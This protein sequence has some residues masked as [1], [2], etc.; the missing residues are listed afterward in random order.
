[1]IRLA[2]GCPGNN[3]DLECMAVLSHSVLKHASEP[4]EIHWLM[5]SRD[6]ASFWYA[7]PQ[8]KPRK[9]W[10][11]RGWATPFS[12]LRLGLPA[13]FKFEGKV[14]YCDSD[15]IFL[16]DCAELWNQPIP[17]GK[18][19]LMSKDGASCVMLMD[20]AR[21][22]D[23][24]PP[25]DKLKSV[26]GM[27]RNVRGAL[28]KAA[29]VYA[30]D[31]NCRDGRGYD[32]I[33]HPDV[34]ILHYTSIPTQPNHRHARAR[35]RAEGKKHWFP[36]P[37]LPHPRKEITELFDAT[38]AEAIAAGRGPETFRVTPEFGDYGR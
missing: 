29:G 5:L 19:L 10:N 20:C 2:V 17:D 38:L 30:G 33:H 26:E 36:G 11:T 4:V 34:K 32:S 7:D 37:D 9:G 13:F 22:R 21:M 16:A 31:W 28:V 15:Q 18:A 25:I 35:L 3:E 8:A 6:P 12:P 14:I 1:M 24:L 27:F 23:V